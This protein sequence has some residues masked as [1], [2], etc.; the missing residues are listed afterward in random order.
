MGMD[1][2][3][4]GVSGE[5]TILIGMSTGNLLGMW[6]DSICCMVRLRSLMQIK[7]NGARDNA[8]GGDETLFQSGF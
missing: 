8:D 3:T 5:S 7:G 6:I 1:I 4:S 2:L